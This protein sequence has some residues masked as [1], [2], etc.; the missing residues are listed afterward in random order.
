VIDEDKLNWNMAVL[1]VPRDKRRK[2]QMSV[3]G[4]KLNDVLVVQN[5][6]QEFIQACNKK[7]KSG[8]KA[9]LAS[10]KDTP[11]FSIHEYEASYIRKCAT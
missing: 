10:L 4:C 5:I 6:C 7:R 8:G 2:I 1:T 11:L 3:G 9:L